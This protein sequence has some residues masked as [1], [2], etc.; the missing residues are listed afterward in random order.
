M[1]ERNFYLRQDTYM[2]FPDGNP[3]IS[4]AVPGSADDKA[5]ATGWLDCD[6]GTQVQL[7]GFPPRR[8]CAATARAVEDRLPDWQCN[9]YLCD[10]G[11]WLSPEF[12]G[13]RW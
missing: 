4:S 5:L 7:D 9:C 6:D 1:T 8:V 3:W 10:D 11:S 12:S 2:G 13:V